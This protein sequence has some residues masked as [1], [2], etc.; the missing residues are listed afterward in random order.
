MWRISTLHVNQTA[1][2]MAE[3]LAESLPV[4]VHGVC[5]RR[6]VPARACQ[7]HVL[8]N[9]AAARAFQAD[10][11]APPM[12]FVFR[13]LKPKPGGVA[14]NSLPLIILNVG[15]TVSRVTAKTR[16]MTQGSL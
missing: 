6:K 14:L 10:P 16:S 8:E 11:L 2:G 7:S 9:A 4:A 1:E 12:A 3:A 5:P 13:V 15:L